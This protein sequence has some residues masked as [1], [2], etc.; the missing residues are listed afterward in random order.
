VLADQLHA[1]ANAVMDVHSNNNDDDRGRRRATEDDVPIKVKNLANYCETVF[2]LIESQR[3]QYLGKVRCVH[4]V[5]IFCSVVCLLKTY[6]KNFLI[7]HSTVSFLLLP[8]TLQVNFMYVKILAKQRSQIISDVLETTLSHF[9]DEIE[10]HYFLATVAKL[11]EA[12]FLTDHAVSPEEDAKDEASTFLFMTPRKKHYATIKEPKIRLS[13]TTADEGTASPGS[14]DSG[15]EDNDAP[16]AVNLSSRHISSPVVPISRKVRRSAVARQNDTMELKKSGESANL[17]LDDDRTITEMVPN[18]SAPYPT[19]GSS[20][21]TSYLGSFID[22]NPFM[23]MVIFVVSALILR[24]AGRMVVTVDFDILLLVIFASFCVGLHTPRPMVGGIDKPPLVK[25]RGG[26]RSDHSGFK[27][28]AKLLR[29][30]MIASPRS[31][32]PVNESGGDSNAFFGGE[33][34]M[35]AVEAEVQEDEDDVCIRSPMP[36]FPEGAPLGSELN[37]WS[38][39]P[40]DTF[41]VRGDTYLTDSKKVKSGPFIFKSRGIDLFLTDD[42]PENVGRYVWTSIR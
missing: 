17:L 13:T 7:E 37:C 35:E 4:W 36:R 23:F 8:C 30:S 31:L 12:F 5:Y 29:R 28:A 22:N 2:Q 40:F 38:D 20:L 18:Y 15:I 34:Q 21:G 24:S 3:T 41:K 25:R 26:R 10:S 9:P 32:S 16:D 11:I 27:N 19:V 42:C 39:P 33:A 6:T 14:Q 1:A